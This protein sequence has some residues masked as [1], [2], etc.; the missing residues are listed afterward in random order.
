[1]HMK[2]F[3]NTLKVCSQS[4]KCGRALEA[5]NDDDM[6]T[7]NVIRD[8]ICREGRLYELNVGRG[9]QINIGWYNEG[10][11]RKRKYDSVGG[12]ATALN[13]IRYKTTRS[14]NKVSV[15]RQ[16]KWA[17]GVD[18]VCNISICSAKFQRRLKQSWMEGTKRTGKT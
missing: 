12:E 1:M 16:V 2:L 3:T 14:R 6:M 11:L 15:D 5:M 17:C 10:I 9:F 18:K 13:I 7:M 4:V 8:V